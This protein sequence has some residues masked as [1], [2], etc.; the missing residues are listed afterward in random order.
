MQTSQAA[1]DVPESG[2]VNLRVMTEAI[3]AGADII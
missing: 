2:G 1:S 3:N